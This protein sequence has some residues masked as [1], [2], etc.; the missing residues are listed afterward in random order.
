MC[1]QKHLKKSSLP[2]FPASLSKILC[3]I[4]HPRACC[5]IVFLEKSCHP[6]SDFPPFPLEWHYSHPVSIST[7]QIL[8][9]LQDFGISFSPKQVNCLQ[10]PGVP[11]LEKIP[12]VSQLNW[13]L[14]S[15]PIL[16]LLPLAHQIYISPP[17]EIRVSIQ[18]ESPEHLTHIQ[19]N[20]G[21]LW[22]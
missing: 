4:P 5:S 22:N 19:Q 13:F 21:R 17:T 16:P 9:L 2:P 18:L 6:V 11:T 12:K 7:Y 20:T 3:L 14:S 1:F 10:V 8:V 15:I